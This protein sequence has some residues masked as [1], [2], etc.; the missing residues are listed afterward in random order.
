MINKD[1]NSSLDTS[2]TRL[3]HEFE[4]DIVHEIPTYNFE[5]SSLQINFNEEEYEKHILDVTS[6]LKDDY[7]YDSFY[8]DK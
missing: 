6:N 1:L 4:Q 8:S 5:P 3:D 7:S 2:P